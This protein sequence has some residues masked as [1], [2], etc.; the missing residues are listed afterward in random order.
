MEANG[1]EK[2]CCSSTSALRWT[3][4]IEVVFTSFGVTIATSG[5]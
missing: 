3:G 4:T 1:V 5:V 2:N